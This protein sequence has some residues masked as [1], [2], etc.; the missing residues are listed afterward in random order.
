MQA[1]IVD[2]Y[3]DED[4][5]PAVPGKTVIVHG[6]KTD[7]IAIADVLAKVVR[8]LETA[9]YCHMHLQDNMSGWRRAEHI[10]LE[11]TVDGRPA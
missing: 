7:I 10:D 9:D 2:A 5:A 3:P 11:V 4:G 6:S 8:H 1:W